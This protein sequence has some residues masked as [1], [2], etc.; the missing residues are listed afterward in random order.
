MTDPFRILP[1]TA[2]LLGAGLLLALAG[3]VG[4]PAVVQP[5]GY[6]STCFAGTYTC[7]LGAQVPVGSQCTCPGLGAPSFGAVR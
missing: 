4:A 2:R 3:C 1:Q 6:G 5:T 7:Q